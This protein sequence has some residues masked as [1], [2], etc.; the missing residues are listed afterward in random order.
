MA[1]R[2][3]PSK[4]GFTAKER[5]D[6]IADMIDLRIRH[7]SLQ[8]IATKYGITRARVHQIVCKAF[9]DTVREPAEKLREIEALR[10]DRVAK[11]LEARVFAGDET[12]GNLYLAVMARRARLLGLDRQTGG[13]FNHPMT[14][15]GTLASPSAVDEGAY[16]DEHGVQVVRVEIIGNPEIT[17]RHPPPPE[18]D[19]GDAPLPSTD[20]L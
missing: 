1:A 11:A 3:P 14:I 5:A 15:D 8:E 7:W 6:R 12:V 19:V 13:G 16:T 2:R 4:S 9:D 18:S 17:R 10:L 20:D